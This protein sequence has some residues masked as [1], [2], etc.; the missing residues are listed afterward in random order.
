M[1]ETVQ[2]GKRGRRASSANRGQLMAR[3]REHLATCGFYVSEP[4]NLRSISFDMIA[5]RDE[6]LL[7]IKV[8]SNID[9]IS[10]SDSEELKIISTT[11]GASP[12]IVGLHSSASELEDGILYSRFG[13]P[14]MSEGSF[15]EL[16]FEGVPP[17]IYAAPGG[18]CVRIDGETLR[19]VREAKNISLGALAEAAGVS[20]KAIQMY[21]SGMG[22][23]V[24]I[25]ARI[26]EFLDEPIVVPIDPFKFTAQAADSMKPLEEL[27]GDNEEIFK[28][29]REIGYVVLPTKRCPFD[30]F[31]REEEL[32][33]TGIVGDDKVMERKAKVVGNLSKVTEKRSVIFLQHETRVKVISGTPLVSKDELRRTDR[34]EDLI[35]LI[36]RRQKRAK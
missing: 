9:S 1:T 15:K 8:L 5:R 30:A 21:E 11:L 26:E 33:L 32:L 17:L 25:A 34:S 27:G 13:L 6:Q 36:T 29:L 3:V 18:L 14:I 19:T 28:M 20:R 10:Q 16:L 31:A 2:K 12:L 4:H 22:A 23:M 35:D 24:E 7:V